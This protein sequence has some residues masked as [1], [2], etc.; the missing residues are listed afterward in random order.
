MA[1]EKTITLD[2]FA[3]AYAEAMTI[4]M[5]M[6]PAIILIAAEFTAAAGICGHLLF[7]EKKGEENG[8]ESEGRDYGTTTSN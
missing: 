4:M 1:K 8:E 5:K 6:N 2:D 7:D 3:K